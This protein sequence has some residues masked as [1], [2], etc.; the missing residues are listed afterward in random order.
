MSDAVRDRLINERQEGGTC[1]QG[2]VHLVSLLLVKVLDSTETG[3][4]L[5]EDAYF[6][7]LTQVL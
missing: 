7:I 6:R 1:A 3:E 5:V 2:E 4:L